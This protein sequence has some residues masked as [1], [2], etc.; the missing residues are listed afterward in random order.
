[1]RQKGGKRFFKRNKPIILSAQWD[2]SE[3][4]RSAKAIKTVMQFL[5]YSLPDKLILLH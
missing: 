5:K 4:K 2:N 3:G 1:V